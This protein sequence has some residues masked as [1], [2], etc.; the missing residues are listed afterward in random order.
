MKPN[1]AGTGHFHAVQFYSDDVALSRLVAGFLAEG[2]AKG[3]A[4]VM[5]ATPEHRALVEAEL[6]ARSVEVDALKHMGELVVLD[7][8]ETLQTFMVNGV[9]HSSTFN[10]VIGRVLD[11]ICRAHPDCTIRAYGEMVNVLWKDGHEA[12]AIRLETLWNELANSHDFKLLCGYS[13]GNFYKGAALDQIKD[14][15]THLVAD[16]D[17]TISVH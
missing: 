10:Y 7:A 4:G 1:P 11:Q 9:P 2:F 12:A 16:T 14:Q 6:R 3:D 13:M 5:I 17:T 8:A 15:H